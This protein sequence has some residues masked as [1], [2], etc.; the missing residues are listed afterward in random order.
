[1][2]YLLPVGH[3]HCVTLKD[4]LKKDSLI[5][6]RSDKYRFKKDCHPDTDHSCV[7]LYDCKENI[8]LHIGFRRGQN[9][10][11]FN[12]KTAKGAWG[13]EE[14]CALDGAFKGEDVTITVYDHGDHFQIL[15]DYRTVHYYKKQCNENIKV[16]SYDANDGNDPVFSGTLA[17][18]TYASFAKFVPCDD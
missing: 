17:L 3:E 15:C 9:K 2:F 4:E 11:V 12:S 6:F 13:A 18:D 14:S 8:V 10:I 7:R 5:V 1:M 16:I